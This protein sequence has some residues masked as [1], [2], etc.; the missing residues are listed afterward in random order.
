MS[1]T[2]S[3]HRI[4]PAARDAGRHRAADRNPPLARSERILGRGESSTGAVVATDLALLLGDHRGTWRRIGWADIASA[5]FS[6]ADQ[7]LAVRLWP[8]GPD[9]R[10]RVPVD[11]RLAA[12]V[13]ER[14]EAARL[15]S[16][17]VRLDGGITG[18]VLA[19]RDGDAVR[20][21]VLTDAAID[22]VELQRESEAAI[23]EIR[24][25]AGI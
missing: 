8:D 10:F 15:L 11:S 1:L 4:S 13:R 18:R 22:S 25:L 17:P 20:W 19:L 6:A 5:Q 23:A 24:S 21:R 9:Q 12:I 7:C 2:I 14:V 16:V 3:L